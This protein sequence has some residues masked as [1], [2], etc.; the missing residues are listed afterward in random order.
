MTT[1]TKPTKEQIAKLKSCLD[2]REEVIK[3]M[4]TYHGKRV[5]FFTQGNFILNILNAF[6]GIGALSSI[7]WQLAE[8]ADP[9]FSIKFSL[10]AATLTVFFL[11]FGMLFDLARKEE[12]HRWLEASYE[13]L[14]QEISDVYLTDWDNITDEEYEKFTNLFHRIRED[15]VVLKTEEPPVLQFELFLADQRRNIQGEEEIRVLR[16]IT[17][18]QCWMAGFFSRTNALSEFLANHNYQVQQQKP[19]KDKKK[20]TKDKKEKNKNKKKKTP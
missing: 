7:G 16:K 11:F 3:V 19:S 14:N 5:E 1:D 8:Q 20:K 2:K 12:K 10:G 4:K 18:W 17:G 6:V 13:R 9:V 15:M